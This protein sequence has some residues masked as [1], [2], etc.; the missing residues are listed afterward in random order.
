MKITSLFCHC[1]F[2][3]Q[4]K[5]FI[6]LLKFLANLDFLQKRFITLTTDCPLDLT[7]RIKAKISPPT[8][9]TRTKTFF[10]P[11]T[12]L[13]GC[14]KSIGSLLRCNK[15]IVKRHHNFLAPLPPYWL[16]LGSPKLNDPT[17]CRFP[18]YSLQPQQEVAR[19]KARFKPTLPKKSGVGRGANQ[20][21]MP[22]F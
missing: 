3:H 16:L 21:R 8:L 4:N 22:I 18:K 13:V 14:S 15:N 9:L 6:G 10:W 17:A 20:V 7:K 2:G 5:L 12:T 1:R 19:P 11:K